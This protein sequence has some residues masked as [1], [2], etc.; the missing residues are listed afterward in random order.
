VLTSGGVPGKV[1]GEKAWQL[2]KGMVAVLKETKLRR[3]EEPFFGA[4]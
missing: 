1:S 2:E 4:G 3:G